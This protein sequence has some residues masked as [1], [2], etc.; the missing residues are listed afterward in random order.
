MRSTSSEDSAPLRWSSSKAYGK[1]PAPPR[2]AGPSWARLSASQIEPLPPSYARRAMP[3]MPPKSRSGSSSKRGRRPRSSAGAPDFALRKPDDEK[4]GSGAQRLNVA[5]LRSESYFARR[6]GS[7]K[8]S[9]AARTSMKAEASA[10]LAADD[11]ALT[12]GCS[13][14]ARRI[15]ADFTSTGV[16]DGEIPRVAYKSGCE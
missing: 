2:N 4:N 7:L 15:K 1:S 6:D 14:F 8:V 5:S 9:Y 3:P 12:S 13:S 10:A 16:A 11:E